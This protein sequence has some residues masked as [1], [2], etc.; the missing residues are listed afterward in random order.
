[1]N[2]KETNHND[3][4]QVII[5]FRKPSITSKSSKIK[6]R[7]TE[8][9]AALKRWFQLLHQNVNSGRHPKI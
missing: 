1:M 3:H 2:I 8:S 9:R 4:V 5:M 6:R 7:E